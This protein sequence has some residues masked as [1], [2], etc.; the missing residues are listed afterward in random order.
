MRARQRVLVVVPQSVHS[1][2]FAR[3]RTSAHVCGCEGAWML[4]A[5][6][7]RPS[8]RVHPPAVLDACVRL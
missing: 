5:T 2:A 4:V 8:K 3:E 1:R 7:V 6:R